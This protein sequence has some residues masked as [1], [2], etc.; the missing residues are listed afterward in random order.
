M[1]WSNHFPADSQNRPVHISGPGSLFGRCLEMNVGL[2]TSP[3]DLASHRS[4]GVG[5]KSAGQVGTPG[6]TIPQLTVQ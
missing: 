6:F 4:F 5:R 3:A 2:T 1:V